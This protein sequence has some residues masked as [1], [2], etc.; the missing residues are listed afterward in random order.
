MRGA[1]ILFN[2]VTLV[3]VILTLGMI[4][5][6]VAIA[7]DITAPPF[8]AP[9]TDVPTPTLIPDLGTPLP[10]PFLPTFTPSRTP[11]PTSAPE[12]TL[13][14]DGDAAAEATAT[15]TQAPRMPAVTVTPR[16]LAPEPTQPPP[17][18]GG[19]GQADETE[20]DAVGSAARAALPHFTPTVAAPVVAA[21]VVAAALA[22]VRPSATPT[23]TLTPGP[24]PTST[25]TATPQG[26]APPTL[27][28]YPFIVQ[29]G[30][31]LLRESFA[32]GTDGCA[33][34]GL[35]GTVVDQRGEAV[36]GVEV[37]VRGDASGEQVALAGTGTDYGPSGWQVRLGGGP[38]AERVTIALWSGDRLL[39]PVVEVT[40]P[41]ACAQNLALVNFIQTRTF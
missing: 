27:A 20:S 11:P 15:P 31:P 18:E 25:V 41:A 24:R 3:F 6:A 19:E 14:P 36:V 13:T 32:H 33:W 5:Y 26:P 23:I 30:T 28:P 12:L 29:P 22:T 40:F 39:S 2:F 35:A 34:Q 4:A 38:S 17:E 7:G 9:P 1:N 37:R 8:L 16:P 21:P 10:T